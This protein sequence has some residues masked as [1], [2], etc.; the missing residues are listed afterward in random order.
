L[1]H[2]LW[3]R[4]LSHA[5]SAYVPFRS[6]PTQIRGPGLSSEHRSAAHSSSQRS[7]YGLATTPPP[8]C[9]SEQ[10]TPAGPPPPVGVVFCAVPAAFQS[11]SPSPWGQF[12][13][14]RLPMDSDWITGRPRLARLAWVRCS[15]VSV[16]RAQN[17][18]IQSHKMTASMRDRALANDPERNRI[19]N[20]ARSF[21]NW[22]KYRQ[23]CSELGRMSDREL[24]DLGIGRSDIPYVARQAV[25]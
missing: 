5:S 19:M 3:A 20:L 16:F 23:T 6:I 15:I 21:N 8:G 13:L 25:K 9:Q 10:A 17:D 7:R 14:R 4:A 12:D 1:K 18:Y 2:S 22:R 24:N 11:L